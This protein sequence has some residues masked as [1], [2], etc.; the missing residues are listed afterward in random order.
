MW[1]PPNVEKITFTPPSAV[2][3]YLTLL[4]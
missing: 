3:N 4:C 1:W 2:V